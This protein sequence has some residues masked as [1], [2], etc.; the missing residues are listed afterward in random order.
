MTKAQ[1]IQE[2]IHKIAN[3]HGLTYEQAEELEMTREYIRYVTQENEID[4]LPRL[5]TTNIKSNC[6]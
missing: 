2:Y 4:V 5:T 3:K 1:R 6:C